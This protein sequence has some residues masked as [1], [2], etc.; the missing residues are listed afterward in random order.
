[1][2]FHNQAHHGGVGNARSRGYLTKEGRLPER[3][4]HHA[5]AQLSRLA[6]AAAVTERS[7]KRAAA[8]TH[9]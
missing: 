9:K 5:E 1:M 6:E 8:C 3:K 2:E 4:G 7:M